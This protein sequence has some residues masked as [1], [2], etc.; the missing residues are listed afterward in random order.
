MKGL[1]A[2]TLLALAITTPARAGTL[3]R[4][5]DIEIRKLELKQVSP[6]YAKLVGE[7]I[8]HCDYPVSVSF[9]AIIRNERGGVE[10]VISVLVDENIES[11]ESFPF[12][13]L[14]SPSATPP[15]TAYAWIYSLSTPNWDKGTRGKTT[16]SV[17]DLFAPAQ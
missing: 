6:D 10:D 8:N 4:F 3:C 2:L 17:P 16:G 5:S 11:G 1:F 12:S 7:L 15:Y 9:R 13:E 14:V